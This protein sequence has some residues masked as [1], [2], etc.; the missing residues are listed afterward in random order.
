MQGYKI[1]LMLLK[2]CRFSALKHKKT[3]TTSLTILSLSSGASL[4]CGIG[5]K[6][7]LAMNAV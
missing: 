6:Q 5:I 3:E 2:N 4:I 1:L 7:M